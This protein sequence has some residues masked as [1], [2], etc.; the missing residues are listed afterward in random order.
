M[1]DLL[2]Q[3]LQKLRRVNRRRKNIK[4]KEKRR[5]AFFVNPYKFTSQLQSEEKSRYKL[6]S[7]KRG[8]RGVLTRSTFRPKHHEPLGHSPGTQEVP[9]PFSLMNEKEPIWKEVMD[10]VGKAK[11]GSVPGPNTIQYNNLICHI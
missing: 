11:A 2:R 3:K 8:D 10:D 7:T 4:M 1:R 6:T 9:P 5:A